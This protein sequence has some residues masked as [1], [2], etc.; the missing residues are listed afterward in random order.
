M[1]YAAKPLRQRV[2]VHP[3]IKPFANRSVHKILLRLLLRN[4][5][6]SKLAKAEG[7][8]RFYLQGICPL[9]EQNWTE[10]LANRKGELLE[11]SKLRGGARQRGVG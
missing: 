9:P 4:P 6:N 1:G 2:I 7:M 8:L 3:W 5:H 10:C 11:G